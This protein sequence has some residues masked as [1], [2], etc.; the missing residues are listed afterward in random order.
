MPTHMNLIETR[1]H[2]GTD[3]LNSAGVPASL[4][5]TFETPLDEFFTRSHAAP[6]RIDAASWR[7]VVDGLVARP[8]SLSL[9]DLHRFTRREVTATLL[10]AGLRRNELLSVAPLPGELP[11]GPEPA[12]NARWSGVSLR[13]VLDAAGLSED[14][15]HIEFTGLDAVERHGSTFGFGGSIT[16]EKA[17]DGDV[18]LALTQNG[19]PL[20]AEHGFPVRTLV[21]GWI[22]ARSVKWLG[23][24]TASR[25]PSSNYFQTKAYRV[26]REPDPERPTDVTTGTPL[27][28]MN[29]NAVIADP[30]PGDRVAAGAVTV[31]GWAVGA[32]GAQVTAVEVSLDDGA[33]W[34]PATLSDERARWS[35]TLWQATVTLPAGVHQV[36]VRAHDTTGTP[37]PSALRE[38]WNVKGYMNNSWH[39]VDVIAR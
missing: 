5:G 39:R 36:V 28:E 14:A 9:D 34:Q 30:A 33:T 17:Q 25:E 35:W 22:G 3:G 38:A 29:L 21:P 27:A 15:A 18:L 2:H 32:A 24:I 37:Q 8:L 6:P 4:A 7:L 31:R 16:R 12:G 23:R 20:R 13:D 1:L 10:C 19:E 11:W 26:R